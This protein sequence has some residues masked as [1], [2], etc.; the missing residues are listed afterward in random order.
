MDL[1]F[2][3]LGHEEGEYPFEHSWRRDGCTSNMILRYAER[4]K[5]KCYVHHKGDKI[6]THTP[7]GNAPCATI[8]FCIFGNHAYW[9]S[10]KIEERCIDRRTNACNTA[11]RQSNEA[12][13]AICDSF[14]NKE[15]GKIF[16]APPCPAY[17]E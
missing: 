1:I 7:E 8:H 5:L 10:K 13:Y 17:K 4:K 15:V 11:S 14:A 2:T 6:Q 9:Y 3:E 12:P 16:A